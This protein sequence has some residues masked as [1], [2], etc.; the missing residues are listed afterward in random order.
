MISPTPEYSPSQISTYLDLI[1]LPKAYRPENNPTHD[2]NYLTAL[3]AHQISTIPYE[4]L[5]LHYARD[6]QLFLDP[7]HL[8]NKVTNNGRGGYCME[9]SIFFYHMLKSLGFKVYM[10]GVRIRL[11]RDGVHEGPYVGL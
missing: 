10:S 6:R 9:V 4:N 1:S 3:F 2:I 7:Q 5:S 8:F 11:R